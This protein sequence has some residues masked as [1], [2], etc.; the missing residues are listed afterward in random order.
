L[1]AGL[2]APAA[3]GEDVL[4]AVAT[5]FTE[6]MEPLRAG[7]EPATG[8]EVTVVSGSTGKLYAQITNGA[9]FD[10]FLAA[11]Q[12]RPRRLDED[13]AA[14]AGT[15]FT[16]AIGR[17][18]LWSPDAGLIGADG[19]A[20]LRAGDFR[21]LAMA[22]PALAPYGVAARE[23]LQALG[24]LGR[25]QDRIVLGENIGQAHAMIATGNAELGFVALSSVLSPRNRTPG[26]RWDVPQTLYSPIRQDAVLLRRAAGN[27][28]A[29][30]FVEWLHGDDARRIIERF[31]YGVE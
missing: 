9:P 22:N 27:V 29:A 28:A 12:E 18:A 17:L 3:R 13:G 5:N 8:H 25:L 31:G 6:V 24:L 26:S 21:R 1:A 16:Y 15:R 19:G 4:V 14:V 30:A 23:T 2:H 7:F 20:V 10:V 11:D